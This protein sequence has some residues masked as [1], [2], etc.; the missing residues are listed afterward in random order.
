MPERRSDLPAEPGEGPMR[1]EMVPGAADCS[2][3]E[4]LA[5]AVLRHGE[6]ERQLFHRAVR[7][8]LD[9]HAQLDAS[10]SAGDRRVV[11]AHGPPGPGTP[12]LHP[13]DGVGGD[14]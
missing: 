4:L 3:G 8:L 7:V 12:L 5:G 9:G 2:D 14:R 13:G 11:T 1:I 6:G 10:A